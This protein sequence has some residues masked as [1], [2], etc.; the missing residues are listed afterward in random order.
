[1]CWVRLC[2]CQW[3]TH[4][5]RENVRS[6]NPSLICASCERATLMSVNREFATSRLREWWSEAVHL[7]W[8]DLRRGAFGPSVA[9]VS[10]GAALGV[11]LLL[12]PLV[13]QSVFLV[14]L[15]AVT[16]SAS[17]GGLASGLVAAVLGGF[18]FTFFISEPFG[19]L[20]TTQGMVTTDLSVFAAV[21]LLI[22]ALYARLRPVQ[23][24]EAAARERAEEAVRLRDGF[25]AAAAHDL[26]NPLSVIL[27]TCQAV[28]RRDNA[29]QTHDAQRCSHATRSI[30]SN[31]QRLAAQIDQLLDVAR[32][33]AGR[34]LGIRRAAVDIVPLIER[35]VAAREDT[36]R[37]HSVRLETT[38]E[39]LVLRGDSVRLERVVDNLIVNALKY[40]PLGGS[41]VVSLTREQTYGGSCAVVSVRE[42]GLGVPAADLARI[43]EPL[44]RGGNVG[45]ISGTG[46][47]LASARQIVE[48]HGGRLSAVSR[49]GAGSTCT[50]RLP[51]NAGH[52]SPLPVQQFAEDVAFLSGGVRP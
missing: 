23:R 17:T 40:S 15:L 21:A 8:A 10:S 51:A 31:A 14:F 25:L 50:F 24:R 42:D 4:A 49:E 45:P 18:A 30:E 12:H 9:F 33:D 16:V 39:R 11:A 20:S 3:Q 38:L 19:W 13:H 37:R 1:V 26:S 32:A 52:T 35:V 41:V 22:N 34:P 5:V 6:P 44:R 28:C 47:G 48:E 36:T 2:S 46:I 7:G 29:T 43:F 27:G